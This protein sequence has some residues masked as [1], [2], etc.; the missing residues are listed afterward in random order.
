MT[1]I[2]REILRKQLR[3][4]HSAADF[5]AVRQLVRHGESPQRLQLTVEQKHQKRVDAL[6]AK[7]DAEA[8]HVLAIVV[9]AI[10]SVLALLAIVESA[11]R[12]VTAPSA[13]VLLVVGWLIK[14]QSEHAQDAYDSHRREFGDV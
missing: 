5:A 4:S 13:L 12:S 3:E 7:D 10:A 2:D 11:G 8:M 6:E 9:F 1:K 14:R